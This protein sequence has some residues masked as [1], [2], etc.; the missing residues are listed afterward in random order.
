[1]GSIGR[2]DPASIRYGD[3]DPASPE[4]FEELKRLILSILP[5]APVE[6]V[7][8]SAISGISGK[9]IIDIAVS[10]KD[11]EVKSSLSK[12]T[13]LGF[14]PSGFAGINAP[15][16]LGA[17][18]FKGKAYGVHVYVRERD[19]R[20]YKMWVFFRDYLKRHPAEAKKYEGVKREAAEREEKYDEVKA[21][22]IKTVI[23]KVEKEKK[24]EPEPEKQHVY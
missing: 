5:Q 9:N 8:S 17:I 24:K 14:Q 19:S 12:L 16:L 21:D 4:V 20:T 10:I 23:R 7:G 15:L 22:F 1:M 2:Y 13:G 3:Y 18:I 6:H 11:G